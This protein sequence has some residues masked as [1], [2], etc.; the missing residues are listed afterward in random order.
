MFINFCHQLYD[1]Q[2]NNPLSAHLLVADFV[3]SFGFSTVWD[4]VCNNVSNLVFFK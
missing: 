4:E 1:S 2:Y 3:N